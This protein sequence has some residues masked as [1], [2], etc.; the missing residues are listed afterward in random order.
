MLGSELTSRKSNVAT[1]FA[2]AAVAA[3]TLWDIRLLDLRLFDGV[4]LG[5]LGVYLILAPEPRADFIQRRRS[6]W[7]LFSVIIFYAALG[8]VFHA[9][10]SSLAIAALAIV[11]FVMIGR[12]DWLDSAAPLLWPLACAHMLLFFIQFGA[13]Y[14]FYYVIDYQAIIGG[15]SRIMRAPS[16]MRAAGLFQEPN[17]Y[18]LNLLVIVSMAILARPSRPLTLAA[19]LTALLSE[20]FWG[21]GISI[22][23]VLLNEMRLQQ[24]LR[25]IAVAVG[26]SLAAIATI[27]NAYLW[28]SKNGREA[29]PY[30]YSRIAGILNDASLRERY[31][32][33]TCTF[34]G[35]AVAAIT[36]NANIAKWTF[37]EGLSTQFFR[38]C[39][40]AN[41]LAFLFK[42]FGVVGLLLMFAGFAFALRGLSMGDKLY[43]AVI[44]GVS[45][46]SYPLVTYVIFWLWLPATI[47]LLQ[48]RK[49]EP[50]AEIPAT[51][52]T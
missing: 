51:A 14:G 12:R 30:T 42:S 23:L 28:L 47:G 22:V 40:P 7:I 6:Y 45:F 36:R 27:F 50:I 2:A 5:C 1:F 11:G 32:Q 48:T 46:T 19:A 21:I 44:I 26:I 8:Y 34:D 52:D 3:A 4:A 10:R 13:F 29:V 39:L 38:E 43:I 49:S 24:P 35:G 9:H 16:H 18:C 25:R 41:G 31:I 20:S 17:S 37:G 33:N 15:A